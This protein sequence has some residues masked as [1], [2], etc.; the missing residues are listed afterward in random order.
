LVAFVLPEYK[1]GCLGWIDR[2]YHQLFGVVVVSQYLGLL[3]VLTPSTEQ[4]FSTIPFENSIIKWGYLPIGLPSITLS[5]VDFAE[6][7]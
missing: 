4:V 5:V 3:N 1:L 2:Q 7:L 6:I